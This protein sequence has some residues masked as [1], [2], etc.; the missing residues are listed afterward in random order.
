[1]DVESEI[2]EIIEIANVLNEINDVLVKRETK[3]VIMI[4]K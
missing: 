4:I 2:K 1:M 3:L